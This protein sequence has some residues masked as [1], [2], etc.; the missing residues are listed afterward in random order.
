[1]TVISRYSRQMLHDGRV[2]GA[3][4]TILIPIDRYPQVSLTTHLVILPPLQD[5]LHHPPP[6]HVNV[7][8]PAIYLQMD[9]DSLAASPPYS[10]STTT[11]HRTRHPHC[12]FWNGHESLFLTHYADVMEASS[13]RNVAQRQST[14]LVQRADPGTTP[15]ENY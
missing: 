12:A 6:P 5:L 10:G 1:M 8:S 7:M 4:G 11:I 15:R 9:V 13:C 3:G 14:F 2:K